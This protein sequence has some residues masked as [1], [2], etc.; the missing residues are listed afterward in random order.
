M[1]LMIDLETLGTRPNS[2]I[3]SIGAVAFDE[4]KIHDEFYVNVDLETSLPLGFEIDPSTVYWWLKQDKT[5]GE[6][7]D[8]N[9]FSI[10]WSIN[11]LSEFID[12]H[13]PNEIWANSPSFDL[14]MLKNA[15]GKVGRHVDWNFWV[16]RDFRTFM[17]MARPD[18]IYP[19]VAHNALEEAKAQAETLIRH[20]SK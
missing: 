17:A 6:L 13:D 2:V 19:K 18:R 15:Y 4:D 3:L 7:L 16:E 20:W 9:K 12:K 10:R 14:V 8:K 11:Q 5:A 1:K